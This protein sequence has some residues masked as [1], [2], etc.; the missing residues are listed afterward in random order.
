ML[1]HVHDEKGMYWNTN[2]F[3]AI[4][5]HGKYVGRNLKGGS[6]HTGGEKF[7]GTIARE[8]V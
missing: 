7:V 1:P 6:L 2:K 4:S 8:M 3:K 5:H